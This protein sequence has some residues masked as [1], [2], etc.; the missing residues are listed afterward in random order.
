[1]SQLQVVDDSVNLLVK[2]VFDE[3]RQVFIL[4]RGRESF[5][6]GLDGNFDALC[7]G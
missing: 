3:F 5:Y 1:M 6:L 2:P 7:G 4:T